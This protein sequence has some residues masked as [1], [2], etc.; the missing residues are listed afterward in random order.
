MRAPSLLLLVI[1]IAMTGCPKS[2]EA[3]P[4]AATE[5]AVVQAPEGARVFFVS[6]QDRETVT[7]PVKVVFGVEGMTVKPAGTMDEGTGHHHVI[8]NAGPIGAGEVIPMDATHLHYGKGQVEA[9]IPLSPGK[10]TL[11][12]QFADGG[13][14]SYGPPL[15]AT[16]QVKVRE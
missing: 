9:T 7:S 2:D 16:I 11:T 1:V 13:H 5:T 4:A 15:A 12:M 6:P 10:H 3:A 14:R 8:V